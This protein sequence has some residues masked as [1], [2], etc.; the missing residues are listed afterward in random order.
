[1]GCHASYIGIVR[2]TDVS[3][4][5]ASYIGIVIVTHV[6]GQTIGPVQKVQAVQEEFLNRPIRRPE[7]SVTSYHTALRNI[8]EARRFIKLSAYGN[9]IVY[10]SYE[11]KKKDGAV[12]L[13]DRH[14]LWVDRDC[15]NC[16]SICAEGFRENNGRIRLWSRGS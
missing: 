5:H 16:S 11:S 12:N 2:V 6:S 13:A 3:G 7:T 9:K 4:F 14:L 15:T 10:S 1:M 8:P